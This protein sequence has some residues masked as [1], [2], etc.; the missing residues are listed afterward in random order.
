MSAQII[1]QLQ[2]LFSEALDERRGIVVYSRLEPVEMDR[3]ARRVER[4]TMEK[5]RGALPE[6]TIDQRVLNVQQ[7]LTQMEGDLAELGEVGDI[8]EASRQLQTDEIIWQAFEDIAWML[9]FSD[10]RRE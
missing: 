7:R 3:M 10:E 1:K 8:R 6:E 4:E 9:G 2:T 5:L